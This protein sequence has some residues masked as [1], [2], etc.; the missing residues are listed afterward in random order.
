MSRYTP[1]LVVVTLFLISILVAQ[2]YS[3]IFGTYSVCNFVIQ[4]WGVESNCRTYPNIYGSITGFIGVS[5][6]NS[7]TSNVTIGN[8]APTI[9]DVQMDDNDTSLDGNITL[10]GGMSRFVWCNATVQDLNGGTDFNTSSL[11]ANATIFDANSTAYGAS[12]NA[13]VPSTWDNNRCYLA[14]N[15]TYNTNCVWGRIINATAQALNCTIGTG[16]TGGMWYNANIT[17]N[18][19]Q[20]WNCTLLVEDSGGLQVFG[21]TKTNTSDLLAVGIPSLLDFGSLALGAHSTTDVNHTVTNFGNKAM[22]LQLNGTN[23]SCSVGGGIILVQNESYNCTTYNVDWPF[24]KNLTGSLGDTACS[25]GN[26]FN[27][28]KTLV[29]LA[30]TPTESAKTLP[31]RVQVPSSGAAGY[32]SG[33]IWYVAIVQQ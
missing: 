3:Y 23:M 17:I 12:C 32:C 26:G 10:W 33:T 14:P 30:G 4:P 21:T 7:T 24:R 19:T 13:T 6:T 20:E 11:N 16:S 31:W 18:N 29:P 27:L 5:S 15:A 2:N 28:S 8:Q 25:G 1:L 22:T 9:G